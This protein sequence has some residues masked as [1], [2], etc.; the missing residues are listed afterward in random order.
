MPVTLRKAKIKTGYSFYFD[1]SY[2]GKRWTEWTK[3]HVNEKDSPK[4]K[5]DTPEQKSEK[6]ELAQKMKSERE[7]EIVVLGKGLP[8][9]IH[10]RER[11]FFDVYDELCAPRIRS[12]H[13]CVNIR[14]KIKK[15]NGENK[16]LPILSINKAWLANFLAFLKREGMVNNTVH[17]YFAFM[18]TIL[19]E[20]M[21]LGYIVQN[22]HSL[23]GRHERPKLKRP[24]ADHLTAEELQRFVQKETKNV[25]EQLKQMFLFSCFT[26]LRWSDCQRVTWKHIRN[27]NVKGES[28]QVIVMNQQKTSDQVI[29]PLTPSAK[30][31]LDTLRSE[32][33]Q[34]KGKG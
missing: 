20:A 27:I 30:A 4:G 16:P 15:F 26:G 11:D 32:I 3:I 8:G 24:K 31:L 2:K 23:F 17:Q 13:I 22:P 6:I 25:D 21:C 29:V 10:L 19:R 33:M 9:E 34:S 18:G 28:Q 7:R 5:K 14:K 1:I 12:A